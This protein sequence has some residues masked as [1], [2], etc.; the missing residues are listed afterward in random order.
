MIPCGGVNIKCIKIQI[1][2]F[3]T[4]QK[5]FYMSKF[6]KKYIENLLNFRGWR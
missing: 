3:G 5:N 1:F 2:L 6:E 4:I